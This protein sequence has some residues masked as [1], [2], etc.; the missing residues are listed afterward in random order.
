M[1][2]KD[3][4]KVAINLV[5]IYLAGGLLLAFVYANTSPV[6]FKKIKQETEE[7]LKKLMPEAGSIAEAGKWE[8]LHKHAAYY[9]AK[10]GDDVIGYVAETY[11]KGYSSY[12]HILV[13]SDKEFHVKKIKVL[14]HAETPGLGDE[15]EKD[16]FVNQYDGK[17]IDHLLVL[18]TETTDMIQAISG[19]TISSRAV[20]QGV[21]DGLAFIKDT[22]GGGGTEPAAHQEK[23][24]GK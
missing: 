6:I 11:G 24:A 20:T 19:A 14:G 4:I 17:D 10:T 5:V 1:T 2:A 9:E 8:P 21:K 23:E 18:K 13:A 12:I 7:A 22:Y 3:M 15:I 16:Y